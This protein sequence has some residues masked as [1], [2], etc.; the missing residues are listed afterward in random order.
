MTIAKR[1]L[2]TAAL[3]LCACPTS[4]DTPNPEEKTHVWANP[5]E[6][7]AVA[8][9]TFTVEYRVDYWAGE[10]RTVWQGDWPEGVTV[11]SST[12][13][14]FGPPMG[15]EGQT[16][17]GGV[18]LADVEGDVRVTVVG[19]CP[20]AAVSGQLQAIVSGANN[21]VP[22]EDE[23]VGA[24]VSATIECTPNPTPECG[25]EIVNAPEQCD[26]T[27]LNGQTCMTLT[28]G[29]G[30][31][32]CFPD[33]RFDTSGCTTPAAVCGD[34]MVTPPEQCEPGQP[35]DANCEAFGGTGDL[36]CGADCVFDTSGCEGLADSC[37][38]SLGQ[39]AGGTRCA[40]S[41]SGGGVC[42]FND[43]GSGSEGTRAS[44]LTGGCVHTIVPVSNEAGTTQVACQTGQ[45]AV[46]NQ[47]GFSP[48]PLKIVTLDVNALSSTQE[49]G[50]ES[51]TQTAWMPIIGPNANG[52][53]GLV[54]NG[55]T[56]NVVSPAG[57]ITQSWTGTTRDV[58]VVYNGFAWAGSDVYNFGYVAQDY[59]GGDVSARIEF[60]SVDVGSGAV[61]DSTYVIGTWPDG[62]TQR[63]YAADQID[64]G[65]VRVWVVPED[66]ARLEITDIDAVTLVPGLPVIIPMT[67]G[68]MTDFA[69]V[70][71][72]NLGDAIA[73]QVGEGA[74]SAL[75]WFRW[76]DYPE[77]WNLTADGDVLRQA[78]GF[79]FSMG[80]GPVGPTM[81]WRD[82][83]TDEKWMF[84]AR[85]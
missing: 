70:H 26:K 42:N 28:G 27:N 60:F 84:W 36:G 50:I 56:A 61:T 75:K 21:Y 6:I 13:P 17:Q 34:G 51:N 20:D 14:G 71:I 16:D 2:A 74:D 40:S 52:N 48:A 59:P 24:Y 78:D 23:K 55:E 44:H 32:S 80:G 25:D 79:V 53:W 35:I 7:S 30:E 58:G 37:E 62:V 29:D 69:A 22:R 49:L 72:D 10:S 31:L 4:D 3:L 64:N 85:F 68:P 57:E 39:K 63:F 19:R 5:K 47:D 66:S 46:L 38:V 83:A 65:D 8:G 41:S 77:E 1:T 11:D 33:C 18:T 67:G 76:S 43:N 45:C 82:L 73:A 81:I 54:T 12:P 15:G 9:S